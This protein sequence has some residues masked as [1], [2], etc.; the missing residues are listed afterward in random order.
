RFAEAGFGRVYDLQTMD[1]SGFY[2]RLLAEPKPEWSGIARGCSHP[3]LNPKRDFLH[4]VDRQREQL[5]AAGIDDVAL[6][7]LDWAGGDIA[8]LGL[9]RPFVLL[10][11][12][13]S[14]HRPAKRWPI[15]GYAAL[16]NGLVDRGYQPV[17]IGTGAEAQ[18]NAEIAA[19][20]AQA[21]NLTG[22]TSLFDLASLAREA[23]GAVGND[24]GPMHLV[25]AAG[26]PTLVLFSSASD[27]AL[28]APRGA[29]VAILR[30]DNLADLE[31]AEV[32][33]AIRLR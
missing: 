3:H 29:S 25:A 23:A 11:P 7:E 10:V 26:C 4:T 16:A 9:D 28:C 22:R 30:R 24:N 27:S 18:R 31:I 6:P 21:V 15:A 32:E 14:A 12:G 1:R 8:A 2:Y 33:A 13:G 20:C 5:A 19:A 17:L